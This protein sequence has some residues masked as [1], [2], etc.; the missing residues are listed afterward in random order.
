MK[1]SDLGADVAF[2]INLPHHTGRKKEL[3]RHFKS[4]LTDKDLFT[5]S[6]PQIRFVEGV[7]GSDLPDIPELV[8]SGTLNQYF[9]D[10]GGLFTRNIV[11]CSLAHKKALEAFLKTDS[12]T[13]LILEDDVRFTRSFFEYYTTGVF[14]RFVKES[15][16]VKGW[17]VIYYSK[18][19]EWIPPS[20][21][22]SEFAMKPIKYL[23]CYA[24][25]AYLVNRE[26]AEKLLKKWLPIK[27]P[28]DIYVEVNNDVTVSYHCS[29]FEQFRGTLS[30]SIKQ[31]IHDAINAIVPVGSIL[32]GADPIEFMTETAGL[33]SSQKPDQVD[34][35][36]KAISGKELYCKKQR[37]ANLPE[38]I[39]VR[40][41]TFGDI[42]LPDKTIVKNWATIWFG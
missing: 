8:K 4:V 36:E 12:K 9:M 3:E 22:Y 23:P 26:S 27:F 32:G 29:W 10:P 5:G 21:P 31:P 40:K 11:G 18:Q 33:L 2:V 16:E 24:N 37:H 34:N 38:D 1:L 14:Q 20:E 13:A 25:S 19:W 15:Q 30:P 17:E 28:A 35:Y 6:N 42:Q 41:I 39:P 7:L